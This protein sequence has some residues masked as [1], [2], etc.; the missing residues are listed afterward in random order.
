MREGLHSFGNAPG[1]RAREARREVVEIAAGESGVR[2]LVHREQVCASCD[3]TSGF[4]AYGDRCIIDPFSSNVIPFLGRGW[5]ASEVEVLE[6]LKKQGLQS[7]KFGTAGLD[8]LCPARE[9]SM[10]TPSGDGCIPANTAAECGAMWQPHAA[11]M[12]AAI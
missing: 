9:S 2:G 1:A 11:T 6:S 5:P 7:L 8:P 12:T 4:V 3:R 10:L